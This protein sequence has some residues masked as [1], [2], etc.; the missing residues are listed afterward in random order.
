MK[1]KYFVI[2]DLEATCYGNGEESPDGFFNEIIEIGALKLDPDGNV[3]D[4]FSKFS[5]PKYFPKISKFCNELTTI[6]QSDIDYS[7]DISIVLE[8]FM[9]WSIDSHYVSWGF[10]DKTQI[11]KDLIRN[12]L[13]TYIER[14]EDNHSSL[15]HLHA[16]WN[17]LK[18]NRGVGMNKALVME[19]LELDGTHHRGIDDA[20]NISK[21]FLKYRDKFNDKL[22]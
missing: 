13:E 17:K 3:V 12:D 14:I 7:D 8:E 16:Q 2:F 10:Y 18:R 19:G 11:I 22:N 1:N 4:K 9:I 5:K 15:K 21:I 6:T 20:I